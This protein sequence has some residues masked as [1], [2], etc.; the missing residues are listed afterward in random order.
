MK[1]FFAL[2]LTV[3]SALVLLTGC[4]HEDIGIVMHEDETG[5]ITATVGIEKGAYNEFIGMGVNLLDDAEQEPIEY[6]YKGKSYIA[7]TET[8]EYA[9]FEELQQAL[10]DLTYDTDELSALNS[11]DELEIGEEEIELETETAAE[12]PDDSEETADE[13]AD[14]DNHIFKEVTIEKKS[15]GFSESYYFTATMNA[16]PDDEDAEVPMSSAFLVSISVEMPMPITSA[17]DN[18]VIDGNKVT[19]EIDDLSVENAFSAAAEQSNTAVY[20]AIVV[21]LVIVL[22]GLLI[23]AKARSKNEK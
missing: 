20:V 1:K 3:I 8:K 21:V 2:F 22:L 17:S 13:S 14:V 23:V 15:G 7:L 12:E 4:V 5:K 19:F 10:L 16:V 9:S 18:A 6:E 11:M